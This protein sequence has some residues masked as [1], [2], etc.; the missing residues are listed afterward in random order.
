MKKLRNP[1]KQMD[2]QRKRRSSNLFRQT[3]DSEKTINARIKVTIFVI[4]ALFAVIVFR[5]IHLQLLNQ[6]SYAMKLEEYTALKQSFSSPRGAI[7]DRDGN[8]LVESVS[9]LTIS[10]YP[11]ENISEKEEWELADK[12]VSELGLTATTITERQLKEL[13]I[14]YKKYIE[15]D[16]SMSLLTKKQLEKYNALEADL[17]QVLEWKIE[18]TDVSGL[19]DHTKAVYQ[20]KMRMDS[21]PDTQYKVIAEDVS[22]EQISYL[23]ENSTSFPGFKATFDWKRSY[24][25]A[26]EN[27]KAVLGSVSSQTQGIPSEEKEYYLALGYELNDRI[28]I[29]GLEKTYESYLSGTK[30]VYNIKFDEDGV[31]FLEQAQA[32]KNGYD[33]TLTIDQEYQSKMDALVMDKLK[34]FQASSGNGR[35]NGLYLVAINPNTGAIISMSGATKDRDSGE[36]YSNPTG[37]YLNAYQL[38]S[39]VKPATLYMGLNE[40]VVK[41]GEVIVDAPMNI[42]GTEPF[43]SYTNKGAIN[44]LQAIQQSSNIYMAQIAI[45]LGGSNYVAGQGLN[46]NMNVF[47]LM[48]NYYNMFG[49]GVKTGID[50][51]NEEVG[52]VGKDNLAGTVLYY[53]IGQYDAFTPMQAAQYAATLANG[54]KRIQPHLLSRVSEVNDSETILYEFTTKVLSTLKGDTSLLQRSKTGM[55]MCVSLGNCEV[56]SANVGVVMAAKTGTAEDVTEVSENFYEKVSNS[57]MVAY[58]PADNPEVAFACVAP[59][60][61]N[62]NTNVCSQVVEAASKEYFA[63]YRK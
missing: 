56:S 49:L 55:E 42:K 38:G 51:P 44:D 40:G 46:I 16:D 41:P 37:T 12:L 14:Q 8:V 22:E 26:G 21:I 32:G 39:I 58:G 4:C 47:K 25:E 34:S 27:I 23:S 2:M 59:A 6:A 20:A 60:A 57:S 18:A 45:R 36:F 13:H 29:S 30:A 62:S 33:L 53:S 50:L 5:L 1:F 10:Y 9:S 24:S 35:M 54:G 43:A 28:G 19:S 61:N 31:A 52:V 63:N 11:V 15:K 17:D 48:R 7:L 3:Q